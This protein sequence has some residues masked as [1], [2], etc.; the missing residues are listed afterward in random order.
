MQNPMDAITYTIVPCVCNG[1]I[2]SKIDDTESYE[3]QFHKSPIGPIG[4]TLC[5]L[6]FVPGNGD[7]FKP[8]EFI[9]AIIPM[10]FGGP[11]NEYI[12]IAPNGEKTIIGAY[13]ERSIA[14]VK[15][16]NPMTESSDDSYR[17]VNKRSGAGVVATDNGQT[18]IATGGVINNTLKPFG[19]GTTEN[20]HSTFAQNMHRILSHN[21][22]KS[23]AREQFG[24]YAGNDIDE[25]ASM[26]SPEDFLINYRRFVTRDKTPEKWVSTCEGAYSPYVGPNVEHPEVVVG[27]EV[28]L[29]KA[30]NNDRSRITIEMGA[31]GDSFLN[32]RVDDVLTN[33]K[34]CVPAPGATTAI[35]GNRMRL[36]VS[37][38]GE[39][40]LRAAGGG[41]SKGNK[42]GLH[43]SVDSSGNL[44]I[45]AAGTIK[46]SHGDN[47][48]SNNSVTLD[49]ENGIDI[50]AKNG[51]KVNGQPV[52][53]KSFMDFF[54]KN[55]TQLCQVTSIGGPA[56][57]HP[58]ILPILE[59]DAKKLADS[60]GYTSIGAQGQKGNIG[61]NDDD[62]ETV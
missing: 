37:D 1:K 28:L 41:L 30:I 19:F 11:K 5:T 36:N 57:I 26:V 46:I 45:H 55:K 59:T 8:G 7:N 50:K 39:I 9:K 23:Y 53:L 20:L 17:F 38:K 18:V 13:T 31:P 44:T 33:E 48:S 24:L 61:D 56:P 47:A 43:V 49:P 2:V 3:V 34:F 51:L 22:N 4:A 32:I 29:S 62:F 6:A 10:Q 40:D 15:I 58:A 12:G 21:S 25:K 35:V 16:D 52:L 54:L 27:K 42:S 14:N 60:N